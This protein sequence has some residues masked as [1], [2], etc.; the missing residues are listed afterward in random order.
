MVTKPFVQLIASSRSPKSVGRFAFLLYLTSLCIWSCAQSDPT[1]SASAVS[2][3]ADVLVGLWGSEQMFGP[4]IRGQV[5]IDA[6]NSQWCAQIAGFLIPVEHT[7]K[8]MT[9]RLPGD[10]GEFRGHMSA[11]LKRIVGQWIQ[12][13]LGQQRYVTPI[14]LTELT[15]GVWR[16]ILTPLDDRLSLYVLIRRE[17]DDSITAFIRNPDFNYLDRRSYHAALSGAGVTFLDV[18]NP[19][20]RLDGTYDEKMDLLSI[21]FPDLARTISFT[22][23]KDR[24]AVGFFPRTASDH[25]IYRRP[26]A[27]GDGW[28]TAPLSE[29]GID[30]KPISALVEKILAAD[31]VA[32]PL[33]IHSLLIARHDKLVL[34]EYFYGSD[35]EQPHDMRS[36]AKTFAPVLLG[37][38]IDHGAKL[39]PESPVYALFPEYKEFA[40][41]DARK[42]KITVGN[43]MSMTSG[44]ACNDYD[45]ASVGNEDR[46]QNQSEQPD[47]YKFTLD[48]PMAR[49]PG[50]KQAQY[51]SAGMNLIGGV[52]RNSTGKWIPDFFY[53]YLAAPLQFG[54]YHLNL[55]PTGDVYMGGGFRLRARDELKLG[56]LYL[57]GGLWNGQRIVSAKW[58]DES[59][60]THSSFG[61][62]IDDAVD[63][64]GYGWH[65]FHAAVAGHVYQGYSAGGNGGQFVIV[66]PELDLVVGFNGGSYGNFPAWIRW[67]T[68][69]VPQFV[70]PAVLSGRT[71]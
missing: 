26:V 24:D 9:F 10:V 28:K 41:P 46:M 40:N 61:V 35:D 6:R 53:E 27:A 31:P 34:E 7:Q 33:A 11:D 57:S 21:Q 66:I 20:W 29:V 2:S 5:T 4:T 49:D 13:A 63:D 38:A 39:R 58:V 67:S 70:I 52:L 54:T 25:Y 56:Q 64:Y 45:D 48:L 44:L 62:I 19:S 59:I 16:G 50:G 23:R 36:A 15:K 8:G 30:P 1:Q 3:A 42:M 68:N 69:L 65:I 12:P 71:R 43:V 60:Q 22:R 17:A 37:I 18:R 55:T 14:Q 51:C 47:W 32:N